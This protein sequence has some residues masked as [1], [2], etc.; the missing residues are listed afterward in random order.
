MTAQGEE[1]VVATHALCSQQ[2]APKAREKGLDLAL[3][4][5]IG[6]NAVGIGLGR[7]QGTAIELAVRG[8]R[9]RVQR[10]VDCRHHV[11]GQA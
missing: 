2:L 4:R 3:R 7:P 8:E 10:H 11:L 1:V 6:L 5:F 9:K